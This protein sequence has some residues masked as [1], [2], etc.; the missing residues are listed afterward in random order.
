MVQVAI[1]DLVVQVDGAAG[2]VLTTRESLPTLP[3]SSVPIFNVLVV[4]V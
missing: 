3:V 1:V 4:L 2:L